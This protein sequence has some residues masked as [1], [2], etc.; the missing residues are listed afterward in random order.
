M[1]DVVTWVVWTGPRDMRRWRDRPC[2]FPPR[3]TTNPQ[4]TPEAKRHKEQDCHESGQGAPPD[5]LSE[6]DALVELLGITGT[7]PMSVGVQ[8]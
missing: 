6:P 8:A 1:F 4:L 2:P 3:E 5:Q 7:S